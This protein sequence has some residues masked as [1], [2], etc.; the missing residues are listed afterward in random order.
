MTITVTF[1]VNQK[2]A[3]RVEMVSVPAYQDYV[4]LPNFSEKHYVVASVQWEIGTSQEV[5]VYL[6]EPEQ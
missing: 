6:E 4:R 3:E 5:D 1:Y 2:K